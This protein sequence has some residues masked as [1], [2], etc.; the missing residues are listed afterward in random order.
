MVYILLIYDVNICVYGKICSPTILRYGIW[1][2]YDSH[3]Q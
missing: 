1:L 2:Q 3:S